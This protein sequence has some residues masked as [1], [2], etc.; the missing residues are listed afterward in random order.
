MM[1]TAQSCPQVDTRFSP[2]CAPFIIEIF[3]VDTL[4]KRKVYGLFYEQY[5]EFVAKLLQRHNKFTNNFEDLVA[6]IWLDFAGSMHGPGLLDKFFAQAQESAPDLPELV[7]GAEVATTLNIPWNT[8]RTAWEQRNI[9][10]PINTAVSGPYS[11]LDIPEFPSPVEGTYQERTSM[12]RRADIVE[13]YDE[14]ECVRHLLAVQPKA[15]LWVWQVPAPRATKKHFIH[16][17]KRAVAHRFANFCRTE[18]RR[19]KERVWD[20]F[21]DQVSSVD[22]P[23]SWED[24]QETKSN[25]EEQAELGLLVRKL[26]RTPAS[27][28]LQVLL[29][30]MYD[31]HL[32]IYQAIE[33]CELMTEAEKRTT[34]RAVRGYRPEV[35]LGTINY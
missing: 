20:S 23:A 35:A 27:Q 12:Y 14:Y 33:Q 24:R 25:Q 19:H 31:E 18:E 32:S 8:W 10:G 21:P 30:A 5:Q 22:N 28:H 17:L 7:S 29:M 26:E 11:T 16:Y 13:W 9:Q 15:G 34:V 4:D 3:G 6:R 1:L 2:V